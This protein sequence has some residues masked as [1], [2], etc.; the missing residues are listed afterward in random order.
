MGWVEIMYFSDQDVVLLYSCPLIACLGSVL[1]AWIGEINLRKL[2]SFKRIP[3][4]EPEQSLKQTKESELERGLAVMCI[5]FAGMA[6]GFGVACMFLGS[7]QPTS[8]AIGRI[9]LLALV[10]GFS[11]PTV[12][13]RI[14]QRVAKALGSKLGS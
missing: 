12:V 4:N 8:N 5:A 6:V 1:R 3:A 11:L 7:I 9:W 10:L 2:P 13:D 14:D